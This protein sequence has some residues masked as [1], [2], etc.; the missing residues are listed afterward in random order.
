MAEVA[1]WDGVAL[2]A[3]ER[4]AY[5]NGVPA[6]QIRPGSLIFYAP[7]WPIA[8]AGSHENIATATNYTPIFN[9][10]PDAADHPPM[11]TFVRPPIYDV[12]GR[13]FNA[14]L[15]DFVNTE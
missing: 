8:T 9:G 10:T 11:G 6:I 1:V 13:K 7:L 4:D 12:T 14:C 3:A 15:N 5:H 2:S